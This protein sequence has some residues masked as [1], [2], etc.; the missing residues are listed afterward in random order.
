MGKNLFILAALMTA[1]FIPKPVQAQEEKLIMA[2]VSGV[3]KTEPI[4]LDNRLEK[5]TAFLE[6]YDSPLVPYA[7]TFVFMADKY[8]IDWKLLPAIT[9]VESTFGKQIPFN[10]YNAYGWNNGNYRFQSWEDSIEIVSK[11]LKEKYYN[12]GLDNPY[13]IGRVYA[14]PSPFWGNRVNNFMKM[15]EPISIN[16]PLSALTLTI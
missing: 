16:S 13:K 1:S 7:E 2:G 3:L 8:Q 9:G 12:R 5:L 14:P 4:Q 15:I 11:A 6:K 10:S